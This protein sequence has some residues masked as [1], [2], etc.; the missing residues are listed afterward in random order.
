[1]PLP[2]HRRIPPVRRLRLPLAVLLG[3]A[4]LGLV[5]GTGLAL[6]GRD[7]GQQAAAARPLPQ[8]AAASPLPEAV[9]PAAEALP[10]DLPAVK[11]LHASGK[12]VY[13]H[14]FTPY[15][16]SLDN[17]APG[18]DYYARNYLR[19]DGESGKHAA[20]G[21]LLRDRP[22]PVAPGKGDWQRANLEQEVR[23]ARDAGLDGF[24]V[25][26]LSLSGPNWDRVKLLMAAARTVDPGFRVVLMPDM[27][28]LAGTDPGTLAAR[29]AELAASP[30]AGRFADGRLV[31]SPFKAE[32]KDPGWWSQVL[33]ILRTRHGTDAAL[34]PVFLDFP[35]NAA[36][37]APLSEGFSEWGNRS[38]TA[39]DGAA[40]DVARAKDLGKLWMQP[41]SVQDA[42]P[43]QGVFDEAGN[44]ATL[45]ASW[46]AAIDTDADW[47][48]LTT[49]N[50]YSEGT[51]F[52]P[53]LHNGY[54]YLD[55]SSY[56]LTRFKTGDW[57]RIVRDTVYVTSRTQFAAAS[58][59]QGTAK[60]MRLRGNSAPARDT[61][62]AL[63]FLSAPA[64]VRVL[65]DGA[66]KEERLN[67]GVHPLVVPLRT[68]TAT[69][70]IWR[71]G[72]RTA[73]VRTAYP[74][75]AKPKVQDLQ[76]YAVSSGRTGT[77]AGE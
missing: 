52:A 36:R 3:L 14:Y 48:Q 49:W 74:V 6:G 60:T 28:A 40:A 41:V 50:D 11:T 68:G 73:S 23:T 51:Q 35:A 15:P 71:D 1:M 16:L 77:T 8:G 33:D 13:A 63:A 24:T 27:V 19:P 39:Q 5:A 25:D 17:Q 57:P 72:T 37:F 43:N 75:E 65:Q 18:A 76:Y 30:A 54:T 4:L 45:R 46:Q 69:G 58:P 53:S 10:F 20:Y 34:L 64:A 55:L 56:Y 26:L 2:P 44:T 59:A 61:V 31:V 47:V 70:E 29:L 21:G 22:R 32:A 66:T 9:R 38:Y 7:G 67:T 12:K 42:R 62:E